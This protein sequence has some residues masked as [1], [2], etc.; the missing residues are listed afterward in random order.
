MADIYRAE[1]S[2]DQVVVTGPTLTATQFGSRPA[3]FL[4]AFDANDQW[5]IEA[6]MAWNS[7]DPGGGFVEEYRA[8]FHF[9]FAVPGDDPGNG[10][11]VAGTSSLLEANGNNGAAYMNGGTIAIEKDEAADELRFICPLGTV[12]K[13][14]TSFGALDASALKGH[15]M[16]H[17][18]VRPEVD[19]DGSEKAGWHSFFSYKNGMP[20]RGAAMSS[21]APGVW[22]GWSNTTFGFPAGALMV[23][24]DAQEATRYRTKF[25]YTH[26]TDSPR[27]RGSR[28]WRVW[29]GGDTVDGA[30][31]QETDMTRAAEHGVIWA[32]YVFGDSMDTLRYR[33]TFDKGESYE[34]GTIY[35]QSGTLNNTPNI[36]WAGGRLFAVWHD[37]ADILQA[38][39]LDMGTTWSS[40]V[41]LSITGT[42]PR[43]LIDRQGGLGFY[44][45]I[46]GG[47]LK[48]KRSGDFGQTFLDA[49]PISVAAGVGEQTVAAEFGPDGS[50][51]VGWISGMDWEQVRSTDLGRTWS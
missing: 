9:Y 32:D 20:F 30:A 10:S 4:S 37:G 41:T 24:D 3:L 18:F 46:D 25:S 8:Q 38:H 23:T 5:A 42:H 31:I 14:L 22:S 51:L 12:T 29:I 35:T 33:R 45:Y 2:W 11:L 27:A 13:T 48:L 34:T 1:V 47:D 50:L 40:P 43:H 16:S 7:Y 39:S 26:A 49:T 28:E 19:A 6:R 44:F 21:A 15:A 17:Q 36:E